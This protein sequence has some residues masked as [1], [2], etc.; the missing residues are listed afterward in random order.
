[1]ENKEIEEK[2]GAL[3]KDIERIQNDPDY[4]EKVAR[5]KYGLLRENEMVFEFPPGKKEKKRIK[6]DRDNQ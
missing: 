3:Q 2:N 4:L 1:M 5:D 6:E